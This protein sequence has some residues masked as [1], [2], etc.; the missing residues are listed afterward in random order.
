MGLLT[1][2]L[3][4]YTHTLHT[5]TWALLAF[6]CPKLP[7]LSIVKSSLI[8]VW[9]GWHE[10]AVETCSSSPDEV[11]SEALYDLL[12]T[13]LRKGYAEYLDNY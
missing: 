12:I 5:C 4:P 3:K 6:K 8:A 9:E 11:L 2:I 1:G 10:L 13:P 7:T